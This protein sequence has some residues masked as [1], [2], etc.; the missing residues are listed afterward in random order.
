MKASSEIMVSVVCLAYNAERYIAQCLDG[1]IMQKCNFKYEVVVH[2]DA[3]TDGTAQ[4]IKEYE[5]TYPDLIH[6]IFQKENQYSKSVRILTKYVYPNVKGK[7]I[8]ICEGDDFWTDPFKLQKQYDALEDNPRCRMSIHRVKG[9]KEDGSNAYIS[10]P[11]FTL[12]TG[13]VLSKD[14]VDYNCTNEYVFQTSSYFV[15]TEEEFKYQ[16]ENPTF[17]KVSATGDLAR[18]FYFA[19]KGD[20]YYIDDIMSCYR[21]GST[22]SDARK[23]MSGKSEDKLR[24]HF[25]KQIEM[26]REYD[27]YTEGI[28]HKFCERKINGYLFD[29]AFRNFEYKE[30]IKRKYRVFFKKFPIKARIKICAYAYMPTL[31][32]K[33]D[34]A[35]EGKRSS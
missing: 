9:V 27:K 10:Y 11:N 5:K 16:K 15:L 12:K 19:T 33:Y 24:I 31:L 17:K 8:A 20:I 32:K 22:S 25:N 34:E 26:M 13:V 1:F 23:E 7:Y 29:Q 6:A 28:Y 4:I 18:M 30:M 2:D 21:H 3:S 14:F 35:R